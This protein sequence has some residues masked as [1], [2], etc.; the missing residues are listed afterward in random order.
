M[1]IEYI[2]YRIEA[3]RADEFEAAYAR[4]AAP[5]AASGHCVDFELARCYEEAGRYTLR[6]RWDSL[7]GHLQG[8]RRSGEFREFF[9]HIQP[10][11]HDVEEMQHYTT[12]DVAGLG[13]AQ[14]P[15][16]S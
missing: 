2:R 11:V 7:E 10:F 15:L 4:A 13:A 16:S 14:P 8:F 9:A 5:L 1:I 3:D 12:T 6:I